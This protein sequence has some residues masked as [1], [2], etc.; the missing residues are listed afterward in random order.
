MSGMLEIDV[1]FFGA[2]RKY[3]QNILLNIPY[4]CSAL[5]MKESLLAA[6]GGKDAELIGD[7][8]LADNEGVLS[9]DHIF[10]K[11]GHVSI[12]PPVCGG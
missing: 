7:A 6:L 5:S 2:F 10:V 3:G 12:L 11:G 9:H 4:G 8:A 1:R